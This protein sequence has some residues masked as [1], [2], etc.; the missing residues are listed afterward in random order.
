MR[1]FNEDQSQ[2]GQS[3]WIYE[4]LLQ[5]GI[6]EGVVFEAGAASPKLVCN[7]TIFRKNGFSTLL[8]ESNSEYCEEWRGINDSL[9]T[10]IEAR[11]NYSPSG[12]EN[13]L[14]ELKAPFSLD[15]LFFDIDGGEYQLIEGLDNYRPKIICIEYDNAYPQALILFQRGYAWKSTMQLYSNV[16]AYAVEVL[17]IP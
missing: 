5:C 10:L 17:H 1:Q 14:K 4:F 8:C 12:L 7:S 2:W 6:K 13:I 15:A 11:I 9:I 16:Q 3:E